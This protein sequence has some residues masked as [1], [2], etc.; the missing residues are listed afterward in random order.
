MSLALAAGLALDAA[1][2]ATG[3]GVSLP[4]ITPRHA[5]RLSFHFGLFQFFMPIL[6]YVAGRQTVQYIAA[7]DHW[8]AFG[9]LA[10]VGGHMLYEAF[11]NE[12]AQTPRKDPTRGMSLVVLSVGTSV[13]ALAVGLTFALLEVPVWSVVP[14]IGIVTAGL[15]L[16]GLAAG[17][18]VGS[19]A[20]R[21]AEV[22]GG[23]ILIAIGV[24]ILWQH[25][26]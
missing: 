25:L 18:L 26:Q 19:I 23:I 20:G 6:G 21:S 17:R 4:V 2:V 5:F 12:P 24:K 3:I 1:A 7:W 22:I 10:A 16:G 11:R 9:L 14:V 15:T 13:D 8:V